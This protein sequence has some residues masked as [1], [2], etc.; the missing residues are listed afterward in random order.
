MFQRV[1]QILRRYNFHTHAHVSSAQIVKF[2][3]DPAHPS[4]PRPSPPSHPQTEEERRRTSPSVTKPKSRVHPRTERQGMETAVCQQTTKRRPADFPTPST[5]PTERRLPVTLEHPLCCGRPNSRQGRRSFRWAP[6]QNQLLLVGDDGWC[7]QAPSVPLCRQ[8]AW[9]YL[10]LR[11]PVGAD[12]PT[13]NRDHPSARVRPAPSTC[14]C[15]ETRFEPPN[16]VRSPRSIPA[17]GEQGDEVDDNAAGAG[18]DEAPGACQPRRFYRPTKVLAQRLVE[19]LLRRSLDAL[20][21]GNGGQPVY[22]RAAG[23]VMS[24]AY[25]SECG[26]LF[27]IKHD[28]AWVSAGSID[29]YPH[30]SSFRKAIDDL[31]LAGCSRTMVVDQ[32]ACSGVW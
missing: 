19:L 30:K 26:P 22:R 14:A 31:L 12:M 1:T 13:A 2:L 3:R 9:S 7:R 11:Q 23:W 18:T 21:P 8:I 20:R 27:M 32:S 6:V 25:P 4:P 10:P 29:P 15:V 5:Q 24:S 28:C 17:R 16:E